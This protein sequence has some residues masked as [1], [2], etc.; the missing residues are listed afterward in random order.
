[1]RAV[2]YKRICTFISSLV[3]KYDNKGVTLTRAK[4]SM[5]NT[6]HIFKFYESLTL[7]SFVYLDIIII[8]GRVKFSIARDRCVF[9]VVKL[10]ISF[11]TLVT[12]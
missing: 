3:Y 6:I 8:I 2:Y 4:Q 1:M 11:S 9:F 5:I 7:K 10:Y 12:M